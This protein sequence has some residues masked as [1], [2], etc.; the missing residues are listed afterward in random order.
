MKQRTRKLWTVLIAAVFV[1]AVALG[2]GLTLGSGRR[3]SENAVTAE[4]V[5]G[6]FKIDSVQNGR[7]I[8]SYEKITGSDVGETFIYHSSSNPDGFISGTVG[9]N[10]N[11]WTYQEDVVLL[12]YSDEYCTNRVYDLRPRATETGSTFTRYFRVQ[13]DVDGETLISNSIDLTITAAKPDTS[14]FDPGMTVDGSTIFPALTAIDAETAGRLE[15]IMYY[16][17]DGGNAADVVGTAITLSFTGVDADGNPN[18]GGYWIEYQDDAEVDDRTDVFEFDDDYIYICYQEAGWENPIKVRYDIDVTEAYADAPIPDDEAGAFTNATYDGKEQDFEFDYYSET[19]STPTAYDYQPFVSGWTGSLTQKNVD[20]AGSTITYSATEAG[21]YSVTFHANTGYQYRSIPSAA[22]AVIIRETEGNST[23]EV[24]YEGEALEKLK[25]SEEALPGALLSV[26]YTWNI[27]K[28]TITGAAIDEGNRLPDSWQ[29]GTQPNPD[30]P[31]AGEIALTTNTSIENLTAA[32]DTVFAAGT[33]TYF[34]YKRT[35]GTSYSTELPSDAGEYTWAVQ[36]KNMNNFADYTGSETNFEIYKQEVAL[37]AL[38][39]TIFEY[40]GKSHAPQ[41][42]D[43]PDNPPYGELSVESQTNVGD[44]TATLT[45]T[46]SANFEWEEPAADSGITVSGGTATYSWKITKS[47]NTI[48]NLTITGWTWG[49]YNSGTNAPSASA[50]FGGEITYTYHETHSGEAIDASS[51]AS[52]DAGTYYVKAVSTATNDYD[53]DTAW[54]EF[55]V[56]RAAVAKPGLVSAALTYNGEAQTPSLTVTSEYYT[57]NVTEQILVNGANQTYSAT[58]TLDEN[59]CWEGESG[60]DATAVL[61]LTWRITPAEITTSGALSRD[62]WTYGDAASTLTNTLESTVDFATAADGEALTTVTYYQKND[63]GNFEAIDGEPENAGTY[64]VAVTFT[65]A[66]NANGVSNFEPKTIRSDEFTIQKDTLTFDTITEGELNWMWG[67][68]TGLAIEDF[69]PKATYGEGERESVT[70]TLTYYEADEFSVGTD[71]TVSGKQVSND[72]ANLPAGSYKVYAYVEA[73]TN[74]EAGYKVYDFTVEKADPDSENVKYTYEIT[75]NNQADWTYDDGVDHAITV[76]VKVGGHTLGSDDYTVYYY[77][78]GWTSGEWPTS[79]TALTLTNGSYSLPANANAGEYYI[80]VVVTNTDNHATDTLE[81]DDANAFTIGKKVISIPNIE[82]GDR[83][84]EYAQGTKQAPSQIVDAENNSLDSSWEYADVVNF[85]GYAAYAAEGSLDFSTTAPSAYGGYYLRLELKEPNNYAWEL[86]DNQIQDY[87][88]VISEEKYYDVFYQITGKGYEIEVSATGWTYGGNIT[89]PTF[90]AASGGDN[91]TSLAA[92]LEEGVTVTYTFYRL[93]GADD[94]TDGTLVDGAT[95]TRTSTD[96]S[97]A[98][99]K[100]PAEIAENPGTYRVVVS[101]SE[102]KGQNYAGA[103]AEAKF[104]VSQYALQANDIVWQGVTGH[105]YDGEEVTFAGDEPDIAATYKNWTY[106]EGTG[107]YEDATSTSFLEITLQGGGSILNAG[108]YTLNAELPSGESNITLADGGLAAMSETVEVEKLALSVTAT[109]KDDTILYG[110]AAPTALT[111]YNV[112]LTGALDD[113][114]EAALELL[115]RFAAQNYTAGEGVVCSIV[116]TYTVHVTFDADADTSGLLGNYEIA[117]VDAESEGVVAKPTFKVEKRTITVTIEDKTSVYGEDIVGLAYSI[118]GQTFDDASD[119]FTLTTTATNSSDAGS[120]SISGAANG[121]RAGNYEVTFK[122]SFTGDTTKGTYTI[123]PRQLTIQATAKNSVEYGDSA[124]LEA[125][126]YTVT[127][128]GV[129]E[130][131]RTALENA[132]RFRTDYSAGNNV[133]NYTVYVYFENNSLLKNYS[134]TNGGSGI[135]A[136]ETVATAELNVVARQI[137]VTIDNITTDYGTAKA[138]T[139]SGLRR[140]NGSSSDIVILEK[141]L[142]EGTAA[143]QYAKVFTLALEDGHTADANLSAGVYTIVGTDVSDDYAVTFAGSV[144]TTK[145]SYTVSPKAIAVSYTLNTHD[146]S[147]N[148]VFDGSAWTYTATGSGEYASVTFNVTYTGSTTDGS[149]VNAGEYTVGVVKTS[150]LCLSTDGNY[151]ATTGTQTQS[152][153]IAKRTVTVSWTENSGFVYDGNDQSGKITATY[154]PWVEGAQSTT[155]AELA[156]DKVDFTDWK[157][158]GYTF[159]AGLASDLERQNYTLNGAGDDGK[160]TQHY[161]M[162]KLAITVQI[163]GQE[164]EYGADIVDFSNLAVTTHYTISSGTLHDGAGEVFSLATTATNRSNVGLYNITGTQGGDRAHNYTVTFENGSNAYEITLRKVNVTL[165]EYEVSYKNAAYNAFTAVL[166]THYT[167]NRLVE[168]DDLNITLTPN[169]GAINAGKYAYY[170]CAANNNNYNVTF[171][172]ADATVFVIVPAEITIAI[173]SKESIYGNQLAALECTLT[174]GN[175]YNNSLESV[176]ELGIYAQDDLESPVSVEE[177][178]HLAAGEYVISVVGSEGSSP[179]TSGNFEITFENATYTVRP[180]QVKVEISVV[181]HDGETTPTYDGSAWL[182][183]ATGEGVDGETVEFKVTY[184]AEGGSSLNE[185]GFAVDAGSYSYSVSVNTEALGGNYIADA[186][187]TQ[188]FTIEQHEVKVSWAADEF[189]YNGTDQFASITATYL[190]WVNG[191]ESSEAVSL[192]IGGQKF[193]NADSYTFT[194]TLE[195]SNYTLIADTG[196]SVPDEGTTASKTYQMKQ[197]EITVS[198]EAQRSYYG[199]DIVDLMTASGV[200]SIEGNTYDEPGSIFTLTAMNTNGSPLARGDAAGDYYIRGEVINSNYD[201]TWGSYNQTTGEVAGYTIARRPV[202]IVLTDFNMIYGTDLSESGYR[203]ELMALSGLDFAAGDALGENAAVFVEKDTGALDAARRAFAFAFENGYGATSDANTTWDVTASLANQ[204]AG[205]LSNYTFEMG[206]AE[207]TIIPRPITVTLPSINNYTYGTQALED[208]FLSTSFDETVTIGDEWSGYGNAIVNGDDVSEIYRLFVK[209]SSNSEV[210]LSA[211]TPVGDYTFNGEALSDGNYDVTFANNGEQFTVTAATFEVENPAESVEVIYTGENYYFREGAASGD[212]NAAGEYLFNHGL[213]VTTA[214]FLDSLKDGI[215]Y[216]WTFTVQ[217]NGTV[218]YLTAANTYTVNYTVEA[219]NFTKV[220]G[221]FT[222]KITTSGNRWVLDG[223]MAESGYEFSTTWYYGEAIDGGVEAENEYAEDQEAPNFEPYMGTMVVEYYQTRTGDSPE[224]YSYSDQIVEGA[225]FFD[226]TTA[227]GTYYVKVYVKET[228][229]WAGIEAH[230]VITVEKRTVDINW[231]SANIAIN[232]GSGSGTNVTVG[233]DNT[234]MTLDMNSLPA[235]LEIVGDPNTNGGEVEVTVTA[236]AQTQ[237]SLYFE[238]KDAANYRWPTTSTTVSDDGKIKQIYFSVNATANT[239]V[240]VGASGELEQNTGITIVYGDALTWTFATTEG[241]AVGTDDLLI[242]VDSILASGIGANITNVQFVKT[243]ADDTEPRDHIYG[244]S[245]LEGADAGVYWMRVQVFPTGESGYAY[246]IGYLKVTITQREVGQSEINGITFGA[247]ADGKVH[248]TYNGEQQ[249]P[250]ATNVPEY[251]EVTFGVADGGAINAGDHTVTATISIADENYKF[252]SG[253]DNTVELTVAIAQAPVTV[254]WVEDTFT[255]NG[256]DQLASV[257]AYFVDVNGNVVRLKVSAYSF[258]GGS[259]TEFLTAGDY[260]MQA[261]FVEWTEEGTGGTEIKNY[262]FAKVNGGETHG[263]TMNKLPVVI[264]LLDQDVVYTGENAKFDPNAYYVD[265]FT[266]DAAAEIGRYEDLLDNKLTITVSGEAKN[267]GEYTLSLSGYEGLTN[268]DVTVQG[269]ATLTI[270]PAQLTF[271]WKSFA[272]GVYG[273]ENGISLEDTE[274]N[275]FVEGDSYSNISQFVVITYSGISWK[276]TEYENSTD[277]PTEAGNY[278]VTVQLAPNVEGAACNYSMQAQSRV[279]VIEKATVKVPTIDS[280]TYNGNKQVAVVGES[281]LYSVTENKGGTNAGSYPVVLALNDSDNYQWLT[282]DNVKIDSKTYTAQFVIEKAEGYKF[283][284]SIE[285]WTYG[286]PASRPELSITTESLPEGGSIVY[287]YTGKTNGGVGYESEFAPT[288]AG[289]Y[290]LTVMLRGM[291]NYEDAEVTTAEFVVGRAEAVIDTRGMTLEFVYD[292]TAHTIGGATLN[293]NETVLQYSIAS[294]TNAGTY[295]VTITAKQ[296]DNY[297]LAEVEVTVVVGRQGLSIEVSI[298]G[299]TYGESSKAPGYTEHPEGLT[300]TVE[301][302]KVGSEE[303]STT[304]P[305]NAGSYVV[306]VTY[307]EGWNYASAVGTAVFT[308]EKATAVIDTDEMQ[309]VYTYKGTEQT[310][311]GAVLTSGDAMLVYYNNTFTD[312]PVG[313]TLVVTIYAPETENFNSATK[314]VTITVNKAEMT[315]GVDID[316]WKDWT[317]G[318]TVSEPIITYS[319]GKLPAGGYPEY[320]YTGKMNGD[321]D[322]SSSTAPTEAGTYT[323]KVTLKGMTNYNDVTSEAISFTIA[324][325]TAFINTDDMQT[326]YTYNGSLQTIEGAALNHTE[327]TLQYSI[328]SVT[329]AGTYYVTISA[330]QTNN[331]NAPTPVEVTIT[332]KKANYTFYV[333]AEDWTYGNTA[334]V[335][336][337]INTSGMPT[338]EDYTVTYAYKGTTNGG[339]SY[340]SEFAPTAA[341]EYTVTVT[342]SGMKNYND[343]TSEAISFTIERASITPELTFNLKVGDAYGWTYG[344]THEN[345]QI[346]AFAN[347]DFFPAEGEWTAYYTRTASGLTGSQI[348]TEAGQYTLRVVVEE[349]DNYLAGTSE[350]ISFTI[351]KAAIGFEIEIVPQLSDGSAG[352]TFGETPETIWKFVGGFVP[353]G[354]VTLRYKG[355]TNAGEPY[356]N[357]LAPTA[358][359]E[360]HGVYTLTVTVDESDNYLG[361]MEEATFTICRADAEID[362]SGVQTRFT[363]TGREQSVSSGAVLN[364]NETELV[365]ENNTFTNAGRYEVVIS[366]DRTYNYHGA[367]E[368]VLVVVEKASLGLSVSIQSWTYRETANRPVLYG[369]AGGGSVSY[370]YTGTTNGGEPYSSSTAPT[371]AGRYT[372]TATVAETDNHRGGTASASFYIYRAATVIDTDNVVKEYVFNGE[373]QSVSGGATLNHNETVPVYNSDTFVVVGSYEVEIWAAQTDNYTSASTTV[374]VVVTKAVPA[375]EV[376]LDNWTYGEAANEPVILWPTGVRPDDEKIAI[377]YTGVTNGGEEYESDTAPTLAGEYT[378]T[379]TLTGMS[380]FVDGSRSQ[381][382]LVER[383]AAIIDTDGAETEYTYNGSEQALTSGAVLNHDETVLV[384]RDNTFTDAGR[385][386]VNI[387]AAET[388]NYRAAEV[389]LTVVVNKAKLALEAALEGWMYGETANEPVVTG[390]AGEG[391]LSYRYTGMTNGGAEYD[392]ELAPTQA[393]EY[394]VTVTAEETRNFL[395]GTAEAG[396]IVARAPIEANVS[397]E[398]WYFGDAPNAYLLTPDFLMDEVVRVLYENEEGLFSEN[399]PIYAGDYTISVYY[400]ETENYLAGEASVVFTVIERPLQ[401]SVTLEDWTYGDEENQPV[402]TGAYGIELVYRYTGTAN[403]GT[404][405]DS[406]TAP[407][408]AGSYT[409]TVTTADPENYDNASCSVEFSVLRRLVSA[410]AWNEEGLRE[411]TEEHNGDTNTIYI[412]GYD[413]ALMTA[414]ADGV[415]FEFT[416]GGGAAVTAEIHGEYTIVFTLKDTANY[417]WTDLAEGESMTGPV[418]LT[419]TLTEHVISILWLIILLAVLALIALII[420][421]VLLKKRRKY[422]A[423]KKGG[424]AEEVRL[425]AAAPIG[426]LLVIVP[427]GEIIAAIVLGAAFVGLAVADIV[428]GVRVR[429]L[430]KQ[431]AEGGVIPEERMPEAGGSAPEEGMPEAGAEGGAEVQPDELAPETEGEIPEEYTGEVPAEGEAPEEYTGEVPAEGEAPE[432]GRL[433]E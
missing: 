143:D 3:G 384:Y 203:D 1:I 226:S 318:D 296:T 413:G 183:K 400:G 274:F 376:V 279:Y 421:I 131:D 96:G 308:I 225:G 261:A 45:L 417:G 410:P 159:T 93:N 363:Y 15:V 125:S 405:W 8:Y 106:N 294:V 210:T 186:T 412:V 76:D 184:S 231:E 207:M 369:N 356:D 268:Y 85:V 26:T 382:F 107:E 365:Y 256:E 139:V 9:S 138:F 280:A 88:D 117:Y 239:V 283:G 290:T 182:Y 300:A 377:L 236:G 373:R 198:V 211:S 69:A 321:R 134:L 172:N 31:T 323:L 228:S 127:L 21:T 371:L 179:Y 42:T 145:G 404:A 112:T 292:G 2:I 122:G 241:D 49:Q 68:T 168:G 108:N 204:T 277:V 12:V 196:Y 148:L 115:L 406:D 324:R 167:V 229:D 90:E 10:N 418:T 33:H 13:V 347:E 424:K 36:L 302:A 128:D 314:T 197:A 219:D 224:N 415:R 326:E 278:I 130:G 180:K 153:T 287:L 351:Q 103:D 152:F 298:E 366:A 187:V 135:T 124:S 84:L 301:Y 305:T 192:A 325:A 78:R 165:S 72:F 286:E 126:A 35:N 70:A 39:E 255:Y 281:A 333:E 194:A 313:G 202:Q 316:A 240:F 81:Y 306:R 335:P 193:I 206:T 397:I 94:T 242:K 398:D 385:Y 359:N 73:G 47:A 399:A 341:G 303:F 149:A 216:T 414:E 394:V 121:S 336:E 44:Y 199:E 80:G 136:G 235:G 57:F 346:W 59:H 171:T 355:T 169:T 344:E 195:D 158:G 14:I 161:D 41:L 315:I 423:D 71:G 205:V 253:V 364:H 372:V 61:N 357:F 379:V 178:E 98:L 113:T 92:A 353:E 392:S 133:G 243:T 142:A 37:P 170:S 7:L 191:E 408:K 275:G 60:E 52:L 432:E 328:A 389:T 431:A 222:V 332:V 147:D 19:S 403:D 360:D 22:D 28:A 295:Y 100:M 120:Y 285:G 350:P 402:V 63:S 245:T 54:F 89:L 337:L 246:G 17:V 66:G 104:T 339:E 64:Y 269:G 34:I 266:H 354:S 67:E 386:E 164:S 411:V 361:G 11:L 53:S 190:P 123:K 391:A 27:E 358:A 38:N 258:D 32:S 29:F 212:E 208:A 393:G 343:V 407:T 118:D 181:A 5:D 166:G 175:L 201:V 223:G 319:T 254:S 362:V 322:Y 250:T 342:L 150:G 91:A 299:W 109:L 267:V 352:W 227:A 137:S 272:N 251:L 426:L 116:G 312:V 390:N 110:E 395:G 162:Q 252:A 157:E 248:F 375:F 101:I 374:T 425:G 317:Y 51:L 82:N 220:T 247:D 297:N 209:N 263:F 311:T 214:G 156:I 264:T 422:S 271:D 234:L 62:G 46:D 79:G 265:M 25:D 367:E 238:L 232:E 18:Y 262:T 368:R 427:I 56:K 140:V 155:A 244:L 189:T 111:D 160:V 114:E 291:T 99:G 4:A 213:N 331:Y 200:Y 20:S 428:L 370:R 307:A 48:S 30:E 284:V 282:S 304:V 289:T 293:H 310:I 144:E 97:Y 77:T 340:E 233:F 218:T 309:T 119:I 24:T 288:E 249:L 174:D 396:F 349:T 420:L 388:D 86:A 237:L 173:D 378:V 327:T 83:R 334:I 320:L 276:G 151:Q 177:G 270:T 105:T 345:E 58:V 381:T 330:A 163:V 146:G 75:I 433:P 260:K 87:S 6:D 141:D 188:Y 129:L 154:L 132:L 429:K 50:E 65:Y 409:L 380:N 430:A 102:S 215:E 416:T 23:K 217:G 55:E 383:A 16:A 387:S 43:V 176:V 338:P 257:T 348:P 259:A 273:E 185:A 401:M 74:Y 329:N 230:G 95:V 221:E 40:D 419:W